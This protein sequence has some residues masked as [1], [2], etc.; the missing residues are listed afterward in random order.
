M[1]HHVYSVWDFMSL[2]KDLHHEI[3][4][5]RWPW[6]PAGEASTR[7]VQD[8]AAQGDFHAPLSQR[9]LA[10][11]CGDDASKWREAETAAET[12]VQ[13]RLQ[14]WDGVLAALPNQVS[15]AA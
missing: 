5:A 8:V 4:P 13:A 12:A 7:F 15:Q 14:F 1:Q 9:L 3:A 6:T 10:A 2:T 11:R